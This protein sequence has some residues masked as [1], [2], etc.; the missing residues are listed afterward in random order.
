MSRHRTRIIIE[1]S[2][3]GVDENH[4]AYHRTTVKHGER[5]VTTQVQFCIVNGLVNFTIGE[6]DSDD[7][8]F[9]VDAF[10]RK[11]N[12]ALLAMLKE[13]GR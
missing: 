1:R 3:G 8:Q 7:F 13:I 12:K 11:G 10:D 4:C 2:L 6:A 5:E 9:M